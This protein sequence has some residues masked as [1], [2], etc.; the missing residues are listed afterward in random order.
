MST[1]SDIYY[2]EEENSFCEDHKLN[3]RIYN[4]GH[5]SSDYKKIEFWCSTCNCSYELIMINHLA[6]QLC[7]LL[8]PE[9]VWGDI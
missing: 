1:K 2:K 3:I 6:L 8:P 4:E 7:K 9:Y 5:E